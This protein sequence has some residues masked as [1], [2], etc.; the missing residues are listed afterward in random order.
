MKL[1][2]IENERS[3]HRAL[4]LSL[5]KLNHEVY[6]A[7]SLTEGYYLN[8]VQDMDLVIIEADLMVPSSIDS[9]DFNGKPLLVLYDDVYGFLRPILKNGV[10]GLQK[11]FPL[12]L[13]KKVV[14]DIL[15]QRVCELSA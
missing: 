3:I 13:F 2:I 1:L 6:C 12:S 9:A 11:P 8:Q 10:R 14:S 15:A 5:Q 4:S 7:E